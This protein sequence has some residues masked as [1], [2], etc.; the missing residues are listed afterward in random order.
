MFSKHTA[1]IAVATV[2]GFLAVQGASAQQGGAAPPS[3]APQTQPGQG[4]MGGGMMGGMGGMQ[5]GQ[6]GMGGMMGG[7]GPQSDQAQS[8]DRM[9]Q[10]DPQQMKQMMENCNRMMEGMRN[11]GGPGANPPASPPPNPR[12]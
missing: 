10:M 5:S 6:G 4:P 11:Q 7:M 2:G 3:N 8:G 1:L 9:G 12:G